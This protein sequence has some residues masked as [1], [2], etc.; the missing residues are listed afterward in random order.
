MPENI[1]TTSLLK[2]LLSLLT[3]DDSEKERREIERYDDIKFVDASKEIQKQ[4]KRRKV[5][6]A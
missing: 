1:H 4:E 5:V 2:Y 6:K 3:K